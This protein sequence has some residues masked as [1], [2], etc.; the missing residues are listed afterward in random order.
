MA[1]MFQERRVWL[2]IIVLVGMRWNWKWKYCNC[3]FKYECECIW[4]YGISRIERKLYSVEYYDWTYFAIYDNGGMN[5]WTDIF[6][7]CNKQTVN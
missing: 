1:T 3:V 7:T 4:K 5:Q 6:M 2:Q